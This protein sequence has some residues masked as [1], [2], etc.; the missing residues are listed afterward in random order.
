[1]DR[2]RTRE[3]V[4]VAGHT[5]MGRTATEKTPEPGTGTLAPLFPDGFLAVE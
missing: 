4:V 1:M 5:A 2:A 3:T